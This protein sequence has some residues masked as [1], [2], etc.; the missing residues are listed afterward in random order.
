ME[1]YW[2]LVEAVGA[3]ALGSISGIGANGED[4]LGVEMRS[5]RLRG[6]SNVD[7]AHEVGWPADKVPG[8][9]IS[10]RETRRT[11]KHIASFGQR[12]LAANDESTARSQEPIRL[13]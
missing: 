13:E 9:E 8:G 4:G 11:V 5:L 7:R 6:V 2:T 10:Y 3:E 12:T 1:R